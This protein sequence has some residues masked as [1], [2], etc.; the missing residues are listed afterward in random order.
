MINNKK[1]RARRT[2]KLIPWETSCEA[3]RDD[4]EPFFLSLILCLRI[5]RQ[6]N[7]PK[8]EEKE[9]AKTNN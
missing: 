5:Q 8:L 9:N 3:G 6:K 2:E 7:E 1:Y 4:S